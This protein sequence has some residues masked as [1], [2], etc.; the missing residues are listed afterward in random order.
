MAKPAQAGLILRRVTVAYSLLLPH[1][2]GLLIVFS[3]AISYVNPAQSISLRYSLC[4]HDV[5]LEVLK[6]IALIVLVTK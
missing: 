3:T 1:K 6:V 2:M 5:M 4:D